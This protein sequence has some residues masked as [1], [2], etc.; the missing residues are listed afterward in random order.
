MVHAQ[1]GKEF[2]DMRQNEREMK[3]IRVGDAI[4]TADQLKEVLLSA[5]AF[6]DSPWFHLLFCPW[7][8]TRPVHDQY[9]SVSAEQPTASSGRGS[10]LQEQ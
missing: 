6:Q 8:T 1:V 9:G 3:F 10:I 7:V 2:P 4:R 5:F